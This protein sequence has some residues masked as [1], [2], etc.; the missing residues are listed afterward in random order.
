[1]RLPS[2][3]RKAIVPVRLDS[4]RQPKTLG[5]FQSLDFRHIVRGGHGKAG[6]KGWPD[7]S[8]V[9]YAVSYSS[10]FGGIAGLIDRRI[11][12][13]ASRVRDNINERFGQADK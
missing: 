4:T 13:M 8:E 10:N 6:T 12:E 2:R 11:I 7:P 3:Y 5:E 9:S 1:M